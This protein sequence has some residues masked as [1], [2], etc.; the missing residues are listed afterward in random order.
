MFDAPPSPWRVPFDGTFDLSEAPTAP[1]SKPSRDAIANELA[2]SVADLDKLQRK[3]FADERIAV[4]AMFQGMDAS[5][6][7]STI[8]RVFT[9]VNPAGCRVVSFG[10]PSTEELRHDFLWRGIRALPKRG[11][12][13][14][15]NRSWY[16]EV[17]VVRVHPEILDHQRLPWRPK[18]EALWQSRLRSIRDFE[19]HLAE[20][21]TVILKFFLHLSSD[22]QRRRLV[23]R[24][25]R[26]EKNW[27]IEESDITE[28]GYWDAYQQAYE[29]AL[30]T[31]STAWAP[32]YAIPS[33]HKPF[34]RAA[35]ARIVVDA[36]QSL[37]LAFPDIGE[38]DRS[39]LADYRRR[40]M[41]DA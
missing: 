15:F 19:R 17:A 35:V 13:G 38:A 5:G 16:E 30:R 20:N 25:D 27:K 40:L 32:W 31:T 6:K 23:D 41:D 11:K 26:P 37:D 39:R 28:R 7:D 33:D 8:R 3:L 12:I 9:G 2:Q 21:G 10:R 34:A 18:G 14:V 24:I 1:P 29:A 4:L 36:L 22:E